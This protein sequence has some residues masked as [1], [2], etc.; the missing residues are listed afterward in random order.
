MQ[1]W[2]R[3]GEEVQEDE[4]WTSDSGVMPKYSDLQRLTRDIAMV[5]ENINSIKLSNKE[6]NEVKKLY[7]KWEDYIGKSLDKVGFTIHY[8]GN[9]KLYE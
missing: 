8:L 3:A 6:K 5:S 2:K 1:I 4:V 9:D 7:P